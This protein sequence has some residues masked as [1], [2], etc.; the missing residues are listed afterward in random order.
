[1]M[2]IKL[3]GDQTSDVRYTGEAIDSASVLDWGAVG[4]YGTDSE[5]VDYLLNRDGT[6]DYGRIIDPVEIE[7]YEVSGKHN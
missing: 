5:A 6:C 4:N 7:A 1:M 3:V 2:S